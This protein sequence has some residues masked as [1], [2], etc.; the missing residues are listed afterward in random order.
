MRASRIAH[1]H[2]DDRGL[3]AHVATMRIRTH[4][5][6]M[7]A[8]EALSFARQMVAVARAHSIAEVAAVELHASAADDDDDDD[9]D[10]PLHGT[11]RKVP[12]YRDDRAGPYVLETTLVAA[13][14]LARHVAE[15]PWPARARELKNLLGIRRSKFL[16]AALVAIELGLVVREGQKAGVQYLV[17]PS[18]RGPSAQRLPRGEADAMSF[19]A[20]ESQPRLRPRV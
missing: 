11:S 7:L 15:M 1:A 4:L 18:Y 3:A 19:V 12:M 14:R 8:Q 5:E 2:R 16:R 20:Y 17:G 10:K 9:D 6:L 13:H